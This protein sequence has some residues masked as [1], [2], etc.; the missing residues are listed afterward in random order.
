[1]LDRHT[2]CGHCALFIYRSSADTIAEAVLPI[3]TTSVGVGVSCYYRLVAINTLL[4][5]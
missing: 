5:V 2:T 1:M 3:A 4:T